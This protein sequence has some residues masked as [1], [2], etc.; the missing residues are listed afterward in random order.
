MR[1][2]VR[3]PTFWV[4]LIAFSITLNLL[5]GW[6][7]V[8]HIPNAVNFDLIPP[9]AASSIL[10]KKAPEKQH[11]TEQV[12][13]RRLLQDTSECAQQQQ[14]QQQQQK[15][16]MAV[17]ANANAKDKNNTLAAFGFSAAVNRFLDS[18]D[19]TITSTTPRTT[20]SQS[21]CYF[22]PNHSCHVTKYSVIVV[23]NGTN[24]RQLFLNLMS[25]LSYPSLQDL[26]LILPLDKDTLD[27]DRN[28]GKRLLE[29]NKQKKIRLLL[30]ESSAS[31]SFWWAMQHL[32]QPQSEAVL[33]M[34]GDARKDWNGTVLK[35]YLQM[36]KQQSSSLVV[37]NANALQQ[38]NDNDGA[39]IAAA[40]L[41]PQLHGLVMHR[42]FL[43]YLDHPVINPLRRHTEAL[44]F[45]WEATQ[46]AM[47]MLFQ[48]VAD[49]NVKSSGYQFQTTTSSTSSPSS[50]FS[51]RLQLLKTTQDYFGC[52][53]SPS[54]A[55]PINASEKKCPR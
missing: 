29:W 34:N 5:F 44:G 49:G 21:T 20:S 13:W 22:P 31:A 25:F 14:Q 42:D 8:H 7:A 43:C 4:Y 27:R 37:S 26:T 6:V 32:E 1:R 28:Y 12:L 47:G 41:V 38:R 33:W 24:L 50:V 45:G 19:T 46:N 17:N 55:I 54:F 30:M 10:F 15:K 36:W 35:S 2:S 16:S 51:T 53:K 11:E 40:C 3:R 18:A 39:A 9:I 48:H 23:S 52:C